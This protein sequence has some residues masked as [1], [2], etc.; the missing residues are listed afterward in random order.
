MEI[1]SG[2]IFTQYSISDIS[3]IRLSNHT[4]HKKIFLLQQEIPTG[5]FNGVSKILEEEKEHWVA[6]INKIDLVGEVHY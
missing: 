6:A 3:T 2:V 4:D 5:H 1:I